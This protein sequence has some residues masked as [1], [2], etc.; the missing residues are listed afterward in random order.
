M[1]VRFSDQYTPVTM[2]LHGSDGL[3]VDS[4]FHGPRDEAAAE[5]SGGIMGEAKPCAGTVK[6]LADVGDLEHPFTGGTILHAME[7]FQQRAELGI[8]R[9]RIAGGG[10][11]P[12]DPNPP[13]FEIDIAPGQ[14]LHLRIAEAGEAHQFAAVGGVLRVRV[15]LLRPD[16]GDNGMELLP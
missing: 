14:S 7:P 9:N 16:V 15:A 13:V 1:R 3:E 6:G 10:L 5:G 12:I 4:E 8:D 2:A 11:L